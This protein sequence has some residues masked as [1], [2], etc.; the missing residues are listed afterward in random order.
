MPLSS[1]TVPFREQVPACVANQAYLLADVTSRLE[2]LEGR[3][4]YSSSSSAA[5][6]Q[7]LPEVFNLSSML[8]HARELEAINIKSKLNV[9]LDEINA[10]LLRGADEEA[11]IVEAAREQVRHIDAAA[12]LMARPSW[13]KSG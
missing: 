10:A 5:I 11:A 7:L 6:L 3:L 1:S 9:L 8:T 2:L 13:V 12:R 4:L